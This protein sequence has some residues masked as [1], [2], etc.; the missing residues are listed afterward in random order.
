MEHSQKTNPHFLWSRS[1]LLYDVEMGEN[2][3]KPIF[4][5]ILVRWT[6]MNLSY[7]GLTRSQGRQGF[8]PKPGHP[9]KN[10]M[11]IPLGWFEDTLRYGTPI[12]GTHPH[13]F[14]VIFMGLNRILIWDGERNLVSRLIHMIL[15]GTLQAPKSPSALQLRDALSCCQIEPVMVSMFWLLW[16]FQSIINYQE[17]RKVSDPCYIVTWPN[18]F[19]ERDLLKGEFLWVIFLNPPQ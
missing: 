7:F 4:L 13:W 5:S 1:L 17:V 16:R 15:V 10:W 6:S 14:M 8:D 2:H 3:W 9:T 11:L 12:L 19:L 18:P